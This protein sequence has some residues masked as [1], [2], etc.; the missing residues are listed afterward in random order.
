MSAVLFKKYE[1]LP[2]LPESIKELIM[3]GYYSLYTR[4]SCGDGYILITSNTSSRYIDKDGR[5]VSDEMRPIIEDLN[6]RV[7][8][9]NKDQ[10]KNI[11]FF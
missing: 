9:V 4:N 1:E 7:V 10:D 3:G 11:L 6:N 5:V 2:K 8:F